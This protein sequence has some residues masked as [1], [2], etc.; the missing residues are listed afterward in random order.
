MR[1]ILL[2]DNDQPSRTAVVE[3]LRRAANTEAIVVKD[4]E[5]LISHIR[6]G[7]YAAVFA[8]ADLLGDQIPP[9]IDAVRSAIARPMLIVASN[10]I[11]H[12]LDGDLVT[13]VV[14]KPYDVEILTGILLS[15]VLEM[16]P[17]NTGASDPRLR[18]T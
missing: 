15:A 4:T 7:I 17:P 6:H 10:Q 12:D 18:T 1:R 3:K 8:D 16:P 2:L 14:R 5:E 9:L 13:L 11:H